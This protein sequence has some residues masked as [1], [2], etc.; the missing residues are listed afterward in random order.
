[1]IFSPTKEPTKILVA[2]NFGTFHWL[3]DLLYFILYFLD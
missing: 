3:V 2:Q 1:M